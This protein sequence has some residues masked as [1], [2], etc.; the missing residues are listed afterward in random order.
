LRHYPLGAAGAAV[1]AVVFVAVASAGGWGKGSMRSATGFTLYK[2]TYSLE[3]N[4]PAGQ[5]VFT[6]NSPVSITSVHAPSGFS[7]SIVQASNSFLCGGSG[8]PR[9]PVR[10]AFRLKSPLSPGEGAIVYL[11]GADG[12]ILVTGP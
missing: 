3:F 11:N 6:F 7:C 9:T 1:L 8:R 5:F 10:G 12:P 2:Y 4:V